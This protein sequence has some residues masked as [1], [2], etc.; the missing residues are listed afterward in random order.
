MLEVSVGERTF[1]S[2]AHVD[3]NADKAAGNYGMAAQSVGDGSREA[4]A[5]VGIW[6]FVMERRRGL[7]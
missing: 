5:G 2:A 7:V 3:A 6:F 4:A 1:A